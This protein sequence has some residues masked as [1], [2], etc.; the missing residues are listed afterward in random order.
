MN[1]PMGAQPGT[2]TLK[3]DGASVSGTMSGAQGS[4]DFE[5]GTVDGSKLTWTVEMTQP[6]PM[7]L[8]FEVTV[9]GDEISGD[10]DLGSFGKATL[11]GTRG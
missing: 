10:I 5:G 3:L 1:T 4:Q 2:L 6:M 7:K 8:G 11:T 9:D